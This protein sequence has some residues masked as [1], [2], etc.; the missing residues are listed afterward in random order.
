MLERHALATALAQE[1]VD[2]EIVIVDDGSA[3]PPPAGVAAF[4]D[5]R[6]RVIRRPH[7]GQARARNLG[8]AEARGEWVAFL[9]DDD[10]WA[11][12][13][14]RTQLDS[15]SGG[16]VLAYTSVVFVDAHGRILQVVAA[17]DG[18]TLDD[19]LLARNVIITPSTVMA[20]TDVL[21]RLS[22]FDERLSELMDW[23][24]W[25]RLAQA[26]P[27]AASDE[28]LVGYLI[29]AD[30]RRAAAGRDV[31][32]LGEY[33]YVVGKH[34]EAREARGVRLRGETFHMWVATGHLRSGRRLAAAHVYLKSAVEDRSLRN[35]VR[36][37]AALFGERAS[38]ARLRRAAAP[39]ECPAWLEPI[40]HDL[41][42]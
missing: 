6:V 40:R 41:A 24:L 34:Q 38:L 12:Q 32:I 7:G 37:G 14:L 21:R 2:F 33:A 30:N 27:G 28:P 11:P 17:P 26:G 5:S 16:E 20:R 36:A 25:I 3:K 23:D 29:H 10:L 19:E 9:D 35:L 13:K 1:N 15:V 42:V 18:E 39:P 22:G 31:D 8:I 4:S